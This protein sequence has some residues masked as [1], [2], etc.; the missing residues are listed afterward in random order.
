MQENLVRSLIADLSKKI[1]Y[2]IKIEAINI[3]L[4][5]RSNI[6]HV[7]VFDLNQNLMLSFDDI[8]MDFNLMDLFRKGSFSLEHIDFDKTQD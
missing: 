8:E 1:R 3:D 4:W 5:D 2:P 7:Q 6:S